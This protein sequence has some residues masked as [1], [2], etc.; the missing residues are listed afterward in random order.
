MFFDFI[1]NHYEMILS[2]L[3]VFVSFI[4]AI[5][6]K[7]PVFNLIDEIKVKILEFLPKLIAAVEVPGN[8]STKKNL[9]LKEVQIFLAKEYGFY[10]FDKVEGFISKAIEDI[11]STPTKK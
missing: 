5:I 3:L 4:F 7:K 10:D 1:K 2:I 11:L 8:G 6:K 9:V